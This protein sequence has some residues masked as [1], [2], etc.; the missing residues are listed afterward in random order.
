MAVTS[1]DANFTGYHLQL[2]GYRATPL[3]SAIPYVQKYPMGFWRPKI[4]SP[5]PTSEASGTSGANHLWRKLPGG[6]GITFRLPLIASHGAWPFYWR[7]TGDLSSSYFTINNDPES[8]GYGFVSFDSV[9]AGTYTLTIHLCDQFCDTDSITVTAQFVDVLTDTTAATWLVL[10]PSGSNVSGSA[11]S[12]YNPITTWDG[13]YNASGT[14][15]TWAGKRIYIK[16]SGTLT[17]TVS[18]QLR[19]DNKPLQYYCHL[20]NT[21]VVDGR[22]VWRSATDGQANDWSL[23]GPLTI[24]CFNSSDD[25]TPGGTGSPSWMYVE[26]G[27][28]RYVV[29]GI[30]INNFT[31][32]GSPDN[33]GHITGKLNN[34]KRYMGLYAITAD[35]A[36]N[37]SG[38]GAVV[39][40][41]G[42]RDSV[43]DGVY[44]SNISTFQALVA[45]KHNTSDF[46]MRRVVA[47]NSC[48]HGTTG[49]HSAVYFLGQTVRGEISYVKHYTTIGNGLTL[50]QGAG[51]S[52]SYRDVVAY[53]NSIRSDVDGFIGLNQTNAR[54]GSTAG[55]TRN[56]VQ[57]LNPGMQIIGPFDPMR[58]LARLSDDNVFGS[59]NLLNTSAE[60][61]SHTTGKYGASRVYW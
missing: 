29:A 51:S 19:G 4:I 23:V 5:R 2:D 58:G 61:I 15:A 24:D 53:R 44:C 16:G 6:T 12:Y 46:T 27:G 8:T 36:S 32:V 22:K 56:I 39:K 33:S 55:F 10:D 11:G 42:A 3:T 25:F 57:T 9:P 1:T 7:I 35:T 37:E 26:Y 47:I 60:P 28:D 40:V 18:N 14:D 21:V 38:N 30:T 17:P 54:V 59:Y 13:W 31:G 48:N 52:T 45:A 41:M 50:A 43:I 34:N 49:G 20:S